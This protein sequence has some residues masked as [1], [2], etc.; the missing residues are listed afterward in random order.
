MGNSLNYERKNGLTKAISNISKKVS[1]SFCK[2]E[3]QKKEG[4][5]CFFLSR[6]K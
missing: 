2:K 5:S 3:R 6:L 4:N 1:K